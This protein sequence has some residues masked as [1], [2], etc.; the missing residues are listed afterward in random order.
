MD[1]VDPGQVIRLGAHDRIVLGYL[2]SCWRE[3]ISG[4]TVTVGT[5][6]SEVAG[7]EV[8]RDKVACEG[9]AGRGA[10]PRFS[11]LG[12][13]QHRDFPIMPSPGQRI[14]VGQ[15]ANIRSLNV[16]NDPD[17]VVRRVPL[18]VVVDGERQPSMAAELAARAL[19]ALAATISGSRLPSQIP[20]TMTL[21]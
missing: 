20:N 18:S 9:G 5:E 17:D 15:S 13:A 14:A 3:T 6:Q 7:G 19:G 10:A 21:N 2:R 16:Y 12:E 4:G 8:A 11:V 1:Y